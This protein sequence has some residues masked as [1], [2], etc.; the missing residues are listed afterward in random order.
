M[1]QKRILITL[2]CVIIAI[3]AVILFCY[4]IVSSNASGRTYDDPE[5]IPY[6]KYGMVLGTS[7][8]TRSGLPNY[9]FQNR[10]KAAA[11]LYK[12]GKIDTIIASGG[13]YQESEKH[14]C[15]EP[16]AI[17]DSL[18][19]KGVPADRILL[20]Y[21]GTHTIK[22]VDNIKNKYSLDTI[23][24]ISQ[25]YHNERAIYLADRKGL[26]TIGY[27]AAA[28]PIMRSRVKNALRE[29]LARVKMM[30]DIAGNQ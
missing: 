12:T 18:I 8:I 28:S 7:P 20:D 9:M 24:L 14:G 10:I 30:M 22:S 29:Y 16:Q 21:E 5:E 11:T 17:K 3:A 6:H 1:S 25:K 15:D 26:T 23:T 13:D 2:G 27:N 4:G 19:K